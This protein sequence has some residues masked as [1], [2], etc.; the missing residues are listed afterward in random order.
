MPETEAPCSLRAHTVTVSSTF[1][2]QALALQEISLCR[3][4]SWVSISSPAV[5]TPLPFCW[6]SNFQRTPFKCKS[7]P[8]GI[9]MPIISPERDRS[10]EVHLWLTCSG[11]C[12]AAS[13]G[14]VCYSPCE[15]VL[16]SKPSPRPHCS[17]LGGF[18]PHAYDIP[19][20]F[21]QDNYTLAQPGIQMKAKMLE[22]LVSR[23][24]GDNVQ[25]AP[26][27]G[28]GVGGWKA[29]PVILG[30]PPLLH[31]LPGHSVLGLE[32]LPFFEGDIIRVPAPSRR[33]EVM[34]ASSKQA[35][36]TLI[37]AELSHPAAACRLM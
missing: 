11:G 25:G 35:A 13:G 14:R 1:R 27:S 12:G 22:E 10:L 7:L 36:L 34:S 20:I 4:R 5:L 24:D 2:W 30:P 29:H 15:F 17:P 21:P 3:A 26:L 33:R 31:L 8:L 9:E 28:A 6:Q 18:Y 37:K 16:L 23:S 32:P 19:V